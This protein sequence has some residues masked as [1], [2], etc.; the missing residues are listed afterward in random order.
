LLKL[1]V[2]DEHKSR[3]DSSEGVGSSSLEESSTSFITDDL[4]QAVESSVINPFLLG[5]LRLHLE[6]TTDGV[7]GIRSISSS[8]GGNL[9][10]EESRSESLESEVVF[11]GVLLFERV[12]ETKVDSTVGDDT[13]D[14]NSE[15]VVE[16]EE[17]TGSTS[18]LLE[19]VSKTAEVSL[20]RTDVRSKTSTSVVQRIDD[21]ERSSS[22]K[23]SSGH[24][25]EEKRS[26]LSLGVI[27]RE[28]SFDRVLEGKVEGLGR[29][30]TDN[31]GKVSTPESQHSLF[32]SDTRETVHDTGVTRH[33]SGTDTRVSILGLDDK[34]NTFNGGSKGLGDGSR[35]S[36]QGKVDKKLSDRSLFFGHPLFFFFFFF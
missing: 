8:N 34:L 12:E 9:G 18:C 25:D 27:T 3:S 23:T 29:E 30:I 32:S 19:A 6:T 36:S 5:L 10:D 2:Q 24:L 11:V 13:S 22:S 28:Q 16:T 4:L 26:E 17:S 14:G 21:A 20:S 1:V 7:E 15:S 33:F 31:V 35:G